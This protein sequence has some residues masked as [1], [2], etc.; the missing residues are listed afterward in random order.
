MDNNKLAS[1]CL[2]VLVC[3]GCLIGL[4]AAYNGMS[5]YFEK[6]YAI[7]QAEVEY[8]TEAL[9]E[10][11]KHSIITVSEVTEPKYGMVIQKTMHDLNTGDRYIYDYKWK[12]DGSNHSHEMIDVTVTKVSSNGETT[13]MKGVDD[14]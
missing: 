3:T 5:I 9:Q 6:K 1:W 4:I 13:I 10:A 2:F 14:I 11:T 7:A 12:F 8:Q